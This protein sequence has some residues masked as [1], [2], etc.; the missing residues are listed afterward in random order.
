MTLLELPDGPLGL[1]LHHAPATT[2]LRLQRMCTRLRDLIHGD[3]KSNQKLLAHTRQVSVCTCAACL[4]CIV[5]SHCLWLLSQVALPIARD[6]F[7]VRCG[8]GKVY[9][10]AET[11]FDG[12]HGCVDFQRCYVEKRHML[13]FEAPFPN[14]ESVSESDDD[15]DGG[16]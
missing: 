15:S 16:E 14:G 3:L 13:Q 1:V 6:K 9:S 10:L 8:C 5:F 2:L 4:T 7:I 12:G 11:P